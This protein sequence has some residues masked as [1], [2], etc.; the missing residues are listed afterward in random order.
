MNGS[1]GGL[2]GVQAE[3]EQLEEKISSESLKK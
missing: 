3:E 1:E 2:H